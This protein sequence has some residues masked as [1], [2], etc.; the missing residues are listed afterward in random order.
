MT[1][2]HIF[3]AINIAVMPAWALLIFLPR[4]KITK[5]IV[6]SGLYPL[7][8]GGFYIVVMAM[9]IFFGFGETE[10]GNF[11]SAG[12]VSAL[13]QHPHGVLIGWSHY[14]VFDLFVGAWVGRD[15]QRWN[16]PHLLAAPCQLLCFIFGPI[17]LFCY[18]LLRFFMGKTGFSLDE[19]HDL[20]RKP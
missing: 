1:Y 19:A 10:G 16:I 2:E 4:A 8:L 12:G 3:S 5:Q 20:D 11:F 13:F 9:Q 18:L 15:A 17:G 14:L 7:L 6:H